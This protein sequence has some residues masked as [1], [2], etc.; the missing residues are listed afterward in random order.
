[1]TT[2][3]NY[4][5]FYCKTGGTNPEARGISIIIKQKAQDGLAY[6]NNTTKREL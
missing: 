6:F 2:K 5:E 3:S 4:E 1:M